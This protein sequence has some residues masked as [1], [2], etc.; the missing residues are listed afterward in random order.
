MPDLSDQRLHQLE[1]LFDPLAAAP[2]VAA[3]TP[4][5]Y[6]GGFT[7]L[8]ALVDPEE[9]EQRLLPELK[10]T[11]P[12]ALLR[13]IETRVNQLLWVRRILH[14]HRRDFEKILGQAAFSLKAPCVRA[15]REHE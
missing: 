13:F 6:S 8:P 2:P 5:D 3:R 4:G 11:T 1:T 10:R 12:P 14:R 7:F 9:W 15:Q